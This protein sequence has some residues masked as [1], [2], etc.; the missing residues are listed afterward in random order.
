MII[1]RILKPLVLDG[2]DTILV[3]DALFIGF[4]VGDAFSRMDGVLVG[5]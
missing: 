2:L 1:I 4:V 5:V 3:A